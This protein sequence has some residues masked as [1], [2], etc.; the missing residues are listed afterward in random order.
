MSLEQAARDAFNKLNFLYEIIAVYF[1]TGGP[2]TAEIG[3]Q[4]L[5]IKHTL[6][7][8]L[9][10]EKPEAV[11]WVSLSQEDKH[12]IYRYAGDFFS[13]VALIDAKLKELNWPIQPPRREWVWLTE[14]QITQCIKNVG[15]DGYDERYQFA[16]EI[17]LKIQELNT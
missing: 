12:N 14:E 4:I 3:D 7:Q 8:A 17:E 16:R 2:L 13:I 9:A 1:V 15:I 5:E 11:A 10:Q 6:G